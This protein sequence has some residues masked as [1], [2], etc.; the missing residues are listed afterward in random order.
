MASVTASDKGH[1]R[2]HIRP[3]HPPEGH[4]NSAVTLGMLTTFSFPSTRLANCLRNYLSL[5]PS[6]NF[7]PVT[8]PLL[9]RFLLRLPRPCSSQQTTW[10]T[11]VERTNWWLPLLDREK[12]VRK[13]YRPFH[14]SL[15]LSSSFRME[16]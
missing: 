11:P 13:T 8:L 7:L 6:A 9:L 1:S 12:D 3:F 14:K 4:R 10:P 5:C 16:Y 2:F 15:V